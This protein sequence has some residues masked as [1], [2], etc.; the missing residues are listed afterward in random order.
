MPQSSLSAFFTGVKKPLQPTQPDSSNVP[1]KSKPTKPTMKI[2]VKDNLTKLWG[3][4]T[5]KIEEKEVKKEAIVESKKKEKRRVTLTPKT[6]TVQHD[7]YCDE[8]DEESEDE[9]LPVSKRF[10]K[11]PVQEKHVEEVDDKEDDDKEGDEASVYE[12]GERE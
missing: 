8:E 12:E 1:K 9:V 11:E 2:E 7:D 5:N 4:K 6:K 10:R 3:L